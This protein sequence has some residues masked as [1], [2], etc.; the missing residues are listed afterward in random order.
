[1]TQTTVIKT[2]Q[3]FF[4]PVTP[5][6]DL[7]TT[8]SAV[9]RAT[10]IYQRRRKKLLSLPNTIPTTHSVNHLKGVQQ[11]RSLDSSESLS[12][13]EYRIKT[14]EKI[15]GTIYIPSNSSIKKKY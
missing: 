10:T 6:F 9:Q 15:K 8:E 7:P 13:A 14:S 4:S 5:K 11:S 3:L 12:D 2:T 1:M